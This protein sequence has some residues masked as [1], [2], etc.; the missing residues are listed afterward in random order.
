MPLIKG[1]GWPNGPKILHKGITHAGL[2]IPHFSTRVQVGLYVWAPPMVGSEFWFEGWTSLFCRLRGERAYF[3]WGTVCV[4]HCP[5]GAISKSDRG[6]SPQ[7]P[8]HGSAPQAQQS[9]HGRTGPGLTGL[10]ALLKAA[11][12]ID[13]PYIKSHLQ[14]TN[15]S[16]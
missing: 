1:L 3:W 8:T 2:L 15:P 5:F 12:A 11:Q 6:D 13:Q 9:A 4:A 14:S 10:C 16:F 7:N